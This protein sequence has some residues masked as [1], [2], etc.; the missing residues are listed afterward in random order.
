MGRSDGLLPVPCT[1]SAQNTRGLRNEPT[2]IPNDHLRTVTSPGHP[3]PPFDA[4]LSDLPPLSDILSDIETGP[5]I[6][7]AETMFPLADLPVDIDLVVQRLS[8]P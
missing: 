4:L 7:G 5:T 6:L 8:R 3:A 1:V 2:F